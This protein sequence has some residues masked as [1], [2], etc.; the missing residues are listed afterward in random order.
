MAA[1]YWPANMPD[2][3]RPPAWNLATAFAFHVLSEP[4]L[5]GGIGKCSRL[6]FAALTAWSKIVYIFLPVYCSNYILCVE[7]APFLTCIWHV[8]IL[9]ELFWRKLSLDEHIDMETLKH[10]DEIWAIP[11]GFSFLKSWS[12][13]CT[14][15]ERLFV[16]SSA[17]M[18]LFLQN[19]LVVCFLEEIPA[20]FR[21]A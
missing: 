14:W 8:S 11:L 10:C 17:V 7:S 16:V 19:Y 1:F 2:C 21:L 15:A 13:I 18:P 3:E 20:F 12:S 6:Q 5:Q 4:G 9:S